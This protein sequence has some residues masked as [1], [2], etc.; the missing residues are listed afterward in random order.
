M[1]QVRPPHAHQRAPSIGY[2]SRPQ[3]REELATD[4]LPIDRLKF[5]DIKRYKE[6]LTAAQKETGEKTP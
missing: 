1:P 2:I 4:V 3:G 6:R 5:K